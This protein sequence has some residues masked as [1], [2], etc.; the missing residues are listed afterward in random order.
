MRART[1]AIILAVI[2]IAF[3][4]FVEYGTTRAADVDRSLAVF[5]FQAGPWVLL[6]VLSLL[7]PY[8]KTLAA[9][10]VILLALDV[11]AYFAVFVAAQGEA[12]AM[13]YF[14]KPFYGFALVAVGVLAGFLVSRQRAP[15]S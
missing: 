12:A 5:V 2:G 7:S 4:A 10:G 15:R 6:L 11:Y 3:A 14:Y 8:P 1:F 13:I 9:M